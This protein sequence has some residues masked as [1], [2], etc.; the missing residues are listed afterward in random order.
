MRFTINVI[1]RTKKNSQQI[2]V[3]KGRVI[4]VPSKLYQNFEYEC[5]MLI[6]GECK[7]HIDYPV[8]IKALYF[9]QRDARIDKTNLESALMDMLVKAGVLADDSAIK[10]AIA[11]AHDGSRVYVDKNNPRIEIEITKLEEE[12]GDTKEDNNKR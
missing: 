2:Y 11:V 9:V 8:N 1:P 6:P 5:I 7:K 10:P 12:N 4:A 3:R